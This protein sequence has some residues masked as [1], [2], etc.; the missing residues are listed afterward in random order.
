MI[1]RIGHNFT[2]ALA[3]Q[4]LYFVYLTVK[5]ELKAQRKQQYA[6]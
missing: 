4:I 5:R 3:R 1:I 2:F 6:V